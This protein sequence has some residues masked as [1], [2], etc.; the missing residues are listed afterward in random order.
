MKV[1][2]LEEAGLENA[3]KGLALC[4]KSEY[5]HDK[6][7]RVADKLAHKDGGH[8]KFL[9]SIVVWIEI[10]APIYWWIQFD[11]YRVGVTKQ[12]ESTMHTLL[13]KPVSQKDFDQPI[14]LGV[15]DQVNLYIRSK[16]LDMAKGLLPPAYRQKRIVCLNYK[17]LRGIIQQRKNHRLVE[18]S[19]FIDSIIDQV[20]NPQWLRSC[21]GEEEE[22]TV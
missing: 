11:T 19:I 4:Y 17:V 5:D 22:E 2:V 7:M 20:A 21:Y 14:P 12:S 3:L 16:R 6:M 15:I 1:T 8:N 10:D 13:K 9:E 18:W